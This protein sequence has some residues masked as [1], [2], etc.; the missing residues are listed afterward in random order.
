MFIDHQLKEGPIRLASFPTRF[1]F[2]IS[3]VPSPSYLHQCPSPA[4]RKKFQ[5]YTLLRQHV[6]RQHGNRFSLQQGRIPTRA[7]LEATPRITPRRSAP[8]VPSS[9]LQPLPQPPTSSPDRPSFQTEHPS[10]PA[11][12]AFHR[13]LT[14]FEALRAKQNL[15]AQPP[16][17][18]FRSQAEWE[19]ARWILKSGITQRDTDKLLKSQMVRRQDHNHF[20]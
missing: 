8:P 6:T 3:M 20:W 14:P 18:P 1:P 11:G 13:Y 5:S 2:V 15:D 19:F 12:S 10:Q 16:W 17:H 4:C 7:D 9:P